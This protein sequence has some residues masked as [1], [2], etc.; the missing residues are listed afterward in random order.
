MKNKKI[1]IVILI[2]FLVL[3]AIAGGTYAFL[4]FS[5]TVT[6][7]NYNTKVECFNI[8]YSIVNS[9]GTAKNITGT[10]FPSKNA[11]GGLNGTVSLAIDNSCNIT[12]TGNLYVHIDD[13]T[14]VD[15]LK[16]VAE[17]C[18]NATTLETISDKTEQSA[19]TS[20]GGSWVSNGTGIKYAVYDNATATGTPLKKGYITQTDIGNDIS[21]YSDFS[22]TQT[23]VTY[24][25][26]IWQDGYITDDTYTALPFSG[27]VHA[28]VLQN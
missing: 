21:I 8:N 25:I 22:I 27:Y 18:E 14:S 5:A 15:L 12:G 28:E 20:A 16:T 26:F 7:G 24:Y 17:H 1:R 6:N 11:L 9:D 2:V 13:T 23:V 3:L 19:C 4:T 10:L